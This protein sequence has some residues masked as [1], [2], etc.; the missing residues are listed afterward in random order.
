MT[1]RSRALVN[2]R[3]FLLI[4]LV[5]GISARASGARPGYVLAFLAA[6]LLFAYIIWRAALLAII[7]GSVTWRGT[8]YPLAQMR[9]NRV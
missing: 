1:S 5:F 6:A 9:A 4:V 2:A 3:V 7:R 8:A